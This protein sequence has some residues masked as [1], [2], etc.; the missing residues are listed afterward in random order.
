MLP[1][2]W[3]SSVDEIFQT[4]IFLPSNGPFFISYILQYALLG[5]ILNL[6]RIGDI[7]RYLWK[8]KNA[9]T[10]TEKKKSLEVIEKTKFFNYEL[11]RF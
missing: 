1:S 2:L 7:I 8:S 11:E 9:I 6:L 5:N 10:E 3:L 4:K